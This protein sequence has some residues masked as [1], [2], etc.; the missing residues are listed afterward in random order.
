MY[1]HLPGECDYFYK[2]GGCR[3]WNVEYQKELEFK[4]TEYFESLD[5]LEIK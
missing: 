2:C 4:P 3:F 1:G 5:I